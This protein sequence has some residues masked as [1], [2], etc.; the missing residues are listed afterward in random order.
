[1]SARVDFAVAVVFA[2][3]AGVEKGA[4]ME[5]GR[6]GDSYWESTQWS[7]LLGLLYSHAVYVKLCHWAETTV[8][9]LLSEDKWLIAKSEIEKSVNPNPQMVS[10]AGGLLILP[11][12]LLCLWWYP[13]SPPLITALGA[14]STHSW[15]RLQ[16]KVDIKTYRDQA[17]SDKGEC[18]TFV[19]L[20]FFLWAKFVPF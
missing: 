2:L 5:R 16:R 4:P 8:W 10:A 12:T 1:M 7:T 6:E 20:D 11:L 13:L 3:W 9:H 18:L 14:S 17:I 15:W 19:F